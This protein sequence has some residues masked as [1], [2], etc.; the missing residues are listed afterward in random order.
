MVRGAQELYR[1]VSGGAFANNFDSLKHV[2]RTGK[3]QVISVYGDPD[4]PDNTEAIRYDTTY[5]SAMKLAEQRGIRLD[6]LHLVP[7]GKGATF[8]IAADTL[9]YQKTKVNVVEVGVPMNKFMGK[10]ADKAFLSL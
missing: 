10:Y 2:I 6:S 1:D 5:E 9:S 8:D 4:D 3:V 7:F